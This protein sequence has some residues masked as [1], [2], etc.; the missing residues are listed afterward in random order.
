MFGFF[1]VIGFPFGYLNFKHIHAERLSDPVVCPFRRLPQL[2][3]DKVP[4][5]VAAQVS[6]QRVG[7]ASEGSF[8]HLAQ[9]RADHDGIVVDAKLPACAD[10]V[11]S[12]ENLP[13]LVDVHRDHDA[14]LGNVCLERRKLLR[15]QVGQ[16]LIRIGRHGGPAPPARGWA[17]FAGKPAG[18]P[19]LA[20][21]VT[22]LSP[23]RTTAATAPS[24]PRNAHASACWCQS[25]TME[26]GS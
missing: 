10:T 18:G 22:F 12:V 6:P 8:L 1:S 11:M 24:L 23:S 4:H 5:L 13:V 3:A 15:R 19:C 9:T 16:H 17:A 21:C 25:S 2:R 20:G 26:D 14:A 7:L